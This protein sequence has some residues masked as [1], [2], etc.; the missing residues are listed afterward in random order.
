MTNL[1]AYW[2]AYPSE[3]KNQLDRWGAKTDAGNISVKYNTY[4]FVLKLGRAVNNNVPMKDRDAFV[5]QYISKSSAD[6]WKKYR[7]ASHHNYRWR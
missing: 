1:D 5:K 4:R 2:D 7:R 3:L 6:F